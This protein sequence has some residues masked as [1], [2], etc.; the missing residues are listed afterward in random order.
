M[1][2]FLFNEGYLEIKKIKVE[3][4]SKSLAE[5]E[6]VSTTMKNYD[7]R[8]KYLCKITLLFKN[9]DPFLEGFCF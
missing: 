4:V 3:L 9:Q 1:R 5:H 8:I 2:T 7:L 6:D